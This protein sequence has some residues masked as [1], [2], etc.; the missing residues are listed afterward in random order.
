MT[1]GSGAGQDTPAD[2]SAVTLRAARSD[3]QVLIKSLVRGE[4]LNP[5]SLDWHNF[6]MAEFSGHVV[7][8][9]QVKRHRDGS[10]E[11]ASL[12][13]VPEWRRRGVATRLVADLKARAGPP[14]WLTCRSSLIPFY[15]QFDF[16]DATQSPDV[17]PYFRR[18]RRLAGLLLGL[19]RVR[20]G[21]AVMVWM[22]HQT[23]R[24]KR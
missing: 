10:A 11:L 7:G 1:R 16:K 12:V 17:P 3:E 14:L 24:P 4:H 6:L 15:R 8:C 13:V 19:T 9:G 2:A 5:L 18:I 22:G 23:D 20:D 21:L